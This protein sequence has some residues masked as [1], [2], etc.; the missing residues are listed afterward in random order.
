[1]EGSLSE[2]MLEGVE[3]IAQYT[4]LAPRR[5]YYLCEQ[6]LLP[7]FKLGTKWCAL[8]SELRAAL[9]SGKAA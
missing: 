4:G 7:V 1:M 9:R 2:D 3:K 6:K 8:K 5:V